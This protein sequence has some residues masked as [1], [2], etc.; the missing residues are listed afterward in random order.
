M[1]LMDPGSRIYVAGRSTMAGK[2]IEAK[3]RALRF[4]D[5]IQDEEPDVTDRGAV[6]RFFQRARPEFV[7]VAAGKSAGI[8]GNLRAPADLML[9][10]LL[11]A[12][13][14]IP[15]AWSSGVR[16]L[17]Y[18]ASSCIYPKEAPQPF[19]PSSLWTGPVEPSSHA[20]ATAKLAGIRLCDAYRQQHGADFITA[21]SA[22]AYGPSADFSPEDS[23]VAA[24]LL[25]RIHDARQAA[26][27]SVEIWGSGTP[28]R[29]FIYVDDLAD[30][31]VFAM[32]HYD[33]AEPI[34]LGTGITTSIAELAETIC[35]VV[36]YE[37]ELRFDRSKPDG[38]PLKGLDSAALRA[39]GWT[40]KYDLR[41][42]LITT[43]ERNF[44]LKARN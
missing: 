9:D 38:M 7:F 27:P 26:S 11:V 3:L 42:G 17:L 10:N 36:G 22:D 18:L 1:T 25:R 32:Q 28:R 41:T 19:H 20:Y 14:L 43:Y 5:V 31:C 13:H 6:E 8:A 2:A 4:T 39:L 12:A 23:H 37:G 35:E 34:N 15:A 24:A 21:I 44:K 40:P 30:A 29:E 33:A 16:K